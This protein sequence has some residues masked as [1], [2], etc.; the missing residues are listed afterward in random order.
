VTGGIALALKQADVF[1]EVENVIKEWIKRGEQ[2]RE[3]RKVV[4]KGPD[5]TM[6]QFVGYG[7]KEIGDLPD[8]GGK[9]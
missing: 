9:A 1:E 6:L 3:K 8:I 5:G 7:L 2:R 4:I